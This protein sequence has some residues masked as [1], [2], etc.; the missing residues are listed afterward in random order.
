MAKKTF[1]LE[2]LVEILLSN[3]LLPCRIIR[4]K[5][6]GEII[7]FIIQTNLSILRYIPAT[8]RYLSF[9]DNNATFEL[10]IAG[11]R[12]DSAAS[13]LNQVVKSEVPAYIRFEYPKIVVDVEKLLEEK[14]IKGIRVEDIFF[15]QGQFTVVTCDT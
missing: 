7:H 2:E 13:S 14:N 8:L 12:L 1:S 15:E 6:K 11:G 10:A 3:K 4:P 5:V 9:D